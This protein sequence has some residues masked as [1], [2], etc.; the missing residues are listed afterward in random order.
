MFEKNRM[1]TQNGLDM[2]GWDHLHVHTW[3][4]KFCTGDAFV[5]S[6]VREGI[7]PL[8]LT[9][10]IDARAATRQVLKQTEDPAQKAVLDSR[11]KAL[12]TT[13][14]AL[15]GFTGL[16]P[17]SIPAHLDLTAAVRCMLVIPSLDSGS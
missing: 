6:R 4:I 13:A 8:I 1:K 9:A 5:S 12:K 14:N 11:Q 17:S 2:A 3:R 16:T 15:Y 7:L 10:L